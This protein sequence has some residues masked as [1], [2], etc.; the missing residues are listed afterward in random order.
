[1]RAGVVSDIMQTLLRL[2]RRAQQQQRRSPHTHTQH[3]EAHRTIR[4]CAISLRARGG[5]GTARSIINT[6][7]G[8]KKWTQ[9]TERMS[10]GAAAA[11]AEIRR[12][13]ETEGQ[14][15]RGRG[16]DGTHTERRGE[17]RA[18]VCGTRLTD[19]QRAAFR[20]GEGVRADGKIK[21]DRFTATTEK[22]K[23]RKFDCERVHE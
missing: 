2:R 14:E 5:E 12:R 8:E 7:A 23:K 1:M 17:E 16:R 11:A 13:G 10:G 19:R 21:R 4:R 6:A 3:R 15:D 20:G 18:T 9:N 22:E